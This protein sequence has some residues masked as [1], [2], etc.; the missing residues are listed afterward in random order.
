MKYDDLSNKK[1]GRWLVVSYA[2]SHPKRK[3]ALWNCLCECGNRKI[4]KSRYLIIGR[5][6]S[7]GCLHK[8]IVSTNGGRTK[9]SHYR[10]WKSV[11]DRI[12]NP[13]NEAYKD[14]GG[15][16]L[17]V[18]EEW[19][20]FDIFER[21]IKNILGDKPKDYSLDRVDNN[22]GYFPDNIKWS[23]WSQQAKNRRPHKSIQNYSDDELKEELT[24]R[25]YEIKCLNGK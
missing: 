20:D 21:D 3:T 11:L 25:G 10:M 4:V 8:E 1:F 13:K 15:R 16:G 22:K 12:Y 23:N 5:S 6:K 24:K 2:G 14:Y 9:H 17:G 19:R 18:F 7:C